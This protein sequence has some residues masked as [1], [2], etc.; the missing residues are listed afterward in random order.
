MQIFLGTDHAGFASKESIR[1]RLL[2]QGHQAQDFGAH[3]FEP[4]DDYPDFVIPVARAVVANPDS[5]G[6]VLGGSGQGEGMVANR[7]P[8]IRA[9]VVSGYNPE[10]VTVSRQHNDANVLSLGA[11]FLSEAEILEL[12][13]LFLATDFSND[14]RHV[15]RLHK[16][17]QL[18]NLS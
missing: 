1:N 10:I 7:Y 11:R 12:V 15:R 3:S 6:I 5:R 18:K 2:E 8:G 16:L 9:T 4:G 17:G 13:D 14:E